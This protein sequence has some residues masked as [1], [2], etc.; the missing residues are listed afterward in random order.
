MSGCCPHFKNGGARAIR[1]ND[2]TFRSIW[3]AAK[4]LSKDEARRIAVK[5]A[6]LPELLNR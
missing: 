5:I 2:K 6:K 3:L 1:S 4:L